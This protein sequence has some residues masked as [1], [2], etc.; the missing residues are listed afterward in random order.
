MFE[1]C[2][3][4]TIQFKNGKTLCLKTTD[5][6]TVVTPE[7]IHT[8]PSLYSDDYVYIHP[9][10]VQSVLLTDSWKWIGFCEIFY[11]IRDYFANRNSSDGSD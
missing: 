11:R 3:K 9:G 5:N 7:G 1:R 8:V 6:Y 4:M 2:T 10:S